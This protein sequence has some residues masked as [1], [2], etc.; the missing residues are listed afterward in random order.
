[1]SDH[2]GCW[3]NSVLIKRFLDL[4]W[5]ETF[6]LER[7]LEKNWKTVKNANPRLLSKPPTPLAPA[8]CSV[9]DSAVYVPHRFHNF[10]SHLRPRWYYQWARGRFVNRD[11]CKRTIFFH[12][13]FRSSIIEAVSKKSTRKYAHPST[14]IRKY[15]HWKHSYAQL[16]FS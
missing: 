7:I 15:F 10:Q 4:E 11:F 6:L 3:V 8:F 16:L 14:T 1:M 5:V 13:F 9:E 12:L 2:D